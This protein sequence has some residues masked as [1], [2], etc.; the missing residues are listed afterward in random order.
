MKMRKLSPRY[1]VVSLRVSDE[2]LTAI[3]CLLM[4]EQI[5]ISDL[6]RDALQVVRSRLEDQD[7]RPDLA[8]RRHSLRRLN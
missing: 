7:L 5:T 6:M 1:N 2:D 4:R 3:K 8:A